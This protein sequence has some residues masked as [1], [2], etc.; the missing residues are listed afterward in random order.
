MLNYKV[1]A[2]AIL[3][4]AAVDYQTA[5]K[6]NNERKIA[7]FEKWFVSDWAQFLSDDKGEVILQRCRDG[8]IK[9]S[10]LQWRW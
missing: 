4:Q 5:L 8:S 6:K 1:L 10:N 7:Y 9:C 2:I 3:K